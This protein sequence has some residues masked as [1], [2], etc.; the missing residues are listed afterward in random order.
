LN[1]SRPDKLALP[2]AGPWVFDQPAVS[3]VHRPVGLHLATRFD[4]LFDHPV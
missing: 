2:G 1:S 3:R 4:C